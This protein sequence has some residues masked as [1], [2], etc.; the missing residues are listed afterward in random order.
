[1]GLKCILIVGSVFCF[2]MLKAQ[3]QKPLIVDNIKVELGNL[4][5]GDYSFSMERK[6]A[7]KSSL[8]LRLGYLQPFNHLLNKYDINLSGD[9]T[10]FDTSLEY[11]F[12]L[13]GKQKDKLLGFYAAPYFRYANL[14]LNFLDEI[15]ISP[16][17]VALNYSNIGAGIQL[18]VQGRLNGD[19]N[20]N[21]FLN[22]IIY[23]FHL[24]GGGI[25]WHKLSMKYQ[26]MKNPDEYDYGQ[27]EDD[28]RGYFDKYPILN[29]K[30]QFGYLSNK[31][32]VTL[33]LVLP[34]LRAGFSIGYQF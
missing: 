23:D 5:Y 30:L 1:M 12:F 16:F 27:I 13:L 17:S 25:D 26:A 11:R 21:S 8:S 4:S 32:G 6:I 9:K 19:G 28:I 34:G 14:S 2:T 20:S 33:P 18:G 15:Q 3:N 7:T 31:L 24:L 22:H 29:R 10:G